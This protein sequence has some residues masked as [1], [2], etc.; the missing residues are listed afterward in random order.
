MFEILKPSI[1]LRNG[2]ALHSPIPSNF[3]SPEGPS[4]TFPTTTSMRTEGNV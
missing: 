4:R 3:A 2:L 1:S